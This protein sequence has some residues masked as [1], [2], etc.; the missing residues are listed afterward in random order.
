MKRDYKWAAIAIVLVI[1]AG[2]MAYSLFLSERLRHRD[3]EETATQQQVPEIPIVDKEG[4]AQVEIKLFPYR[5]GETVGSKQFLEEQERSVYKV[6]DPVLMAKQI[7]QELFKD[8]GSPEVET[9]PNGE[10]RK[11]WVFALVRV[12]QVYLLDDGTAVID[13]G[14]VDNQP[15]PRGIVTEMALI[16][17]ITRTLRADLPEIRRVRFLVEGRESDTLM[18]HISLARPFM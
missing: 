17:S 13:L 4:A 1:V 8:P 5:S 16:E 10:P 18:G 9:D 12:R 7:L 14:F 2:Y 15:L 11:P 3:V 6:D